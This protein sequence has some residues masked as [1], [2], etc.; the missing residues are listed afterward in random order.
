[1][2]YC[3]RGKEMRGGSSEEEKLEEKRTMGEGRREQ[4]AAEAWSLE[5]IWRLTSTGKK[6]FSPVGG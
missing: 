1:M 2:G 3:T 5:K 4:Q 6:Y